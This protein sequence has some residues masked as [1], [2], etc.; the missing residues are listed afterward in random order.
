VR[1]SP[2]GIDGRTAR[3]RLI[4]EVGTSFD[5]RG[6]NGCPARSGRTC[7][8]RRSLRR[9][10]AVAKVRTRPICCDAICS[11]RNCQLN[12]EGRCFYAQRSSTAI[13][14]LYALIMT[15]SGVA[16]VHTAPSVSAARQDAPTWNSAM[17]WRPSLSEAGDGLAQLLNEI[18]ASCAVYPVMAANVSGPDCFRH[19]LGL[20]R[21]RHGRRGPRERSNAQDPGFQF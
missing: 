20:P 7:F 6:R 19:R 16:G 4:P 3:H 9:P 17:V 18:D 14:H 5:L 1:S 11:R 21:W 8:V 12:P 15:A 10:D 2:T 13:P